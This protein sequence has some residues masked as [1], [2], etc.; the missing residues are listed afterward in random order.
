M[1]EDMICTGFSSRGINL[2]PSPYFDIDEFPYI[3]TK[4]NKWLC[5]LNLKH[6]KIYKLTLCEDNCAGGQRL[7]FLPRTPNS[8][9]LIDTSLMSTTAKTREARSQA[10]QDHLKKEREENATFITTS[11]NVVQETGNHRKRVKNGC[12]KKFKIN[13]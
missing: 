13:K 3:L 8:N 1:Q 6:N 7:V 11:C 2:E 10:E 5:I 9:D 4:E 12:I